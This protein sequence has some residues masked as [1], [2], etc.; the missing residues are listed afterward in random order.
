MPDVANWDTGLASVPKGIEDNATTKR[1]YRRAVR[2]EENSNGFITVAEP[3]ERK[4]FIFSASWIFVILDPGEVLWDTGAQEGLVGKQQLDN[5]CKLLTEHGLQVEWSQEKPES[6]S[7]IGGVTRPIGVVYV[8]VGL[9][10][11]QR[12]HWMYCCGA[13]R[14]SSTAGGDNEE[15][16]S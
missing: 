8:P 5:W 4:P 7:G 12:Y 13:E 15:T 3:T 2:P 9:A 6:A 11:L 16:P 1:Y 10:G 14:S